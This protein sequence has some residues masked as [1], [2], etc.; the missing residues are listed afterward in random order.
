MVDAHLLKNES[1]GLNLINAGE[2]A[3]KCALGLDG[4]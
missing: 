4:R 2:F 3:G 1:V